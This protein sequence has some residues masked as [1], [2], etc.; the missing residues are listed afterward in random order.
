MA[1]KGI[2]AVVSG[3]SG[4]G[5]GTLMKALLASHPE[6]YALSI[7]ATTR[8]PRAGEEHGREYFFLS[9]E[10]FEGLIAQDALIEYARYVGNYY[11]TPRAYVL[12]QMAAGKDVI[13]E[14]EIQGAL[15][16]KERFPDTL[17]LFVTPPSVAELERRLRSR[18]TETEEVIRGRLCRAAEEAACMDRYDYILVND[19]LDICVKEMHDL[20]QS[21]HRRTS[22][23]QELIDA[24]KAELNNTYSAVLQK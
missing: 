4:A 12:E 19:D 3:F 22:G 5:K 1:Q 24:I 6:Q 15:K 18:G 17:L 8:S 14:I 16:V 20:I 21:Q 9:K 7:S 2:L 10:E 13:L 11:G 23:N